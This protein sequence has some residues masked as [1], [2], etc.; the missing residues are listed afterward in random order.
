LK[1]STELTS[2]ER[3]C[4][5]SFRTY[6]HTVYRDEFGVHNKDMADWVAQD[7]FF[8]DDRHEHRFQELRKRLPDAK[9][10][11]DVASGMGTAA[12]Y[13]L[14][15]GLDCIGIE[16]DVRK[17]KFTHERMDAGGMP[18]EWKAR[19]HRAVGESLPFQT[20]SFDA[21]MS[22]QTLEHVQDMQSVLR[23]MMRVLK[24]SGALY[25][26]C[27]DYRGTYEGHYLLPWLPLMPRPL[28]K[29]Y[30]RL[31]GRPITGFDGIQYTTQGRIIRALRSI[32]KSDP[33]MDL[34]ILD[35]GRERFYQKLAEKGLPAPALAYPIW[36]SIRYLKSLF[37]RDL[38]MDLWVKRK[39]SRS[40]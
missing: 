12:L 25:L 6:V 18:K 39:P 30:L 1:I 26:R 10:I 37:R 7:W 24:P 38:Q 15:Q 22:Y 35:L 21:V 27:P 9:R 33:G 28:A 13:G 14:L 4:L 11:L 20:A 31:C 3:K 17:L 40:T 29:F 2:S 19:F 5:E 34:E 8:C 16:P 36:Q 23:E 32:E